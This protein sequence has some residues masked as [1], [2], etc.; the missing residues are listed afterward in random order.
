[1]PSEFCWETGACSFYSSRL[2]SDNQTQRRY[3]GFGLIH[4]GPKALGN[5]RQALESKSF[6]KARKV[7]GWPLM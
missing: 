6:A 2:T 7:S 1:M 4:S 5:F 3:R